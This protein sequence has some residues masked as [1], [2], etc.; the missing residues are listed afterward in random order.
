LSRHTL[1][2][3]TRLGYVHLSVS[4][5]ER[6]LAFYQHSLGLQVHRRKDN[7]AALGAGHDDLLVLTEQPGAVKPRRHTGLYHFA[8]LVPSRKELAR[9]IKNIIDTKTSITGGADHLVS[10]ALYLDDP[11]GNGIEIYRDRPRATW[12]K[13]NGQVKM[14]V[15]PL[16]Y[17]G[18][19]AEIETDNGEWSGLHIDTVLGHM[20]LHV[21]HLAESTTFYEKVI[22][23]D[24]MATMMGTAAFLSA[25]GY[26][27]HLGIN[28]WQGEGAPAPPS[29]AVGLRYF[30]INLADPEDQAALIGR[31]KEAGVLQREH[32]EGVFIQDPSGNGIVL[33]DNG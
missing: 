4:D 6:S 32:E 18:I 9:S 8:I 30:T 7:G 26:H 21:A 31:L 10:E 22:G 1:S 29:N 20:H 2:P 5:I 24:L 16:D 11:D 19:L 28:T 23:F 27:H 12:E 13:E 25:G 17:Q 14:A 15:N 3:Y 33:T